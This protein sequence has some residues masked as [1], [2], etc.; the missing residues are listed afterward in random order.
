MIYLGFCCIFCHSKALFVMKKYYIVNPCA[1]INN[2]CASC[3]DETAF[4]SQLIITHPNRLK[5]TVSGWEVTLEDLRGIYRVARDKN[6]PLNHFRVA[7]GRTRTSETI[8]FAQKDEYIEGYQSIRNR[9]ERLKGILKERK[10]K[11]R[12]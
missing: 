10:D 3:L 9:P 4:H 8:R 5:K 6:I 11:M 2:L 7:V 12:A 1:D